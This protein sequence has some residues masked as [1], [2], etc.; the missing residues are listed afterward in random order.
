MAPAFYGQDSSQRD[1]P[2]RSSSRTSSS[3]PA[4]ARV[5][6]SKLPGVVHRRAISA[7]CSV[8]AGRSNRCIIAKVCSFMPII[9][10]A[11]CQN[12]EIKEMKTMRKIHLNF[13]QDS[14]RALTVLVTVPVAAMMIGFVIAVYTILG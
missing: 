6:C 9:L 5:S 11:M 4:S 12:E 2:R 3:S 1:F 8:V 10:S 7:C 13:L 14:D